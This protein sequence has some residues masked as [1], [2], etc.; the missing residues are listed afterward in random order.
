MLPQQICLFSFPPLYFFFFLVP[1]LWSLSVCV[2]CISFPISSSQS[3]VLYF[4]P[5]SLYFPYSLS[6]LP[7]LF[8]TSPFSFF[9]HHPSLLLPSVPPLSQSWVLLLKL[10][11]VLG[12][13]CLH[14]APSSWLSGAL[15]A[16]CLSKGIGLTYSA[17][18]ASFQ[19]NPKASNRQRPDQLVPKGDIAG[20]N[21]GLLVL[22]LALVPRF[23]RAGPHQLTVDLLTVVLRLLI[24][25]EYFLLFIHLALCLPACYFILLFIYWG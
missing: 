8:F 11:T 6:F 3:F 13:L 10:N 19:F 5:L 18:T 1:L 4:F 22:S 2:I 21:S 12:L 24:C 23:S 17:A 16:V 7:V 14:A 25:L 15:N 9:Y 20:E